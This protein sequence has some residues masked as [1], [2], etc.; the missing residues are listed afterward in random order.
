MIKLLSVRGFQFSSLSFWVALPLL[1]NTA[2]SLSFLAPRIRPFLFSFCLWASFSVP[3]VKCTNIPQG[4]VLA[5]QLASFLPPAPSFMGWFGAEGEGKGEFL[6][7]FEFPHKSRL[8]AKVLNV[9]SLFGVPKKQWEG[10]WE[11]TQGKQD[12]QSK[13]QNQVRYHCGQLEPDPT[14]ECWESVW[15]MLFGEPGGRG[16]LFTSSL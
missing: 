2:K 5:S 11:V 6:F 12:S 4:L 14:G 16:H 10:A 3:C 9:S 13:V 1:T 8:W 7:W 15:N